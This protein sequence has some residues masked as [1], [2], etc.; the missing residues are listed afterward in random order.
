MC[1]FTDVVLSALYPHNNLPLIDVHIT[2]TLPFLLCSEYALRLATDVNLGALHP[3][4]NLPFVRRSVTPGRH[5]RS[6]LLLCLEYVSRLVAAV[7]LTITCLFDRPSFA[8]GRC[9]GRG[10][11]GKP[12]ARPG[13]P[14]QAG[15]PSGHGRLPHGLCRCVTSRRPP[16]IHLGSRCLWWSFIGL[17]TTSA[18]S[19]VRSL[20]AAAAAGSIVPWIVR[21]QATAMS[22]K[23]ANTCR[24][25]KPSPCVS[26][27]GV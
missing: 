1:S 27:V 7:N 11:R 10:R 19:G 26:A 16:W 21:L 5:L 4:D 8:P 6:F 25:R 20:A 12:M 15:Q 3:H 23:H 18:C 2:P 9:R 22:T 13:H 14:D 17:T 24:E